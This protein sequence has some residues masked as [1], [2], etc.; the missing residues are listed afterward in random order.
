MRQYST[1]L[2]NTLDVTTSYNYANLQN[3]YTNIR[4]LW[5]GSIQSLSTGSY[6][7]I[8][9]FSSISPGSRSRSILSASSVEARVLSSPLYHKHSQIACRS[10]VSCPCNF[11]QWN[12]G[13]TYIHRLSFDKTFQH[14]N[15]RAFLLR[16]SFRHW[17][18]KFD[19][20]YKSRS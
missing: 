8:V 16:N 5:V 18:V 10:T 1:Y 20:C 6:R 14:T 19:I 4:I 9:H 17:R 3:T 7:R 15:Y 11:P 12:S 2:N 13:K